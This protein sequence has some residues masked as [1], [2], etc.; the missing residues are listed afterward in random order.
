MKSTGCVQPLIKRLEPEWGTY[1]RGDLFKRDTHAMLPTCSLRK[2]RGI[3]KLLLTIFYIVLLSCPVMAYPRDKREKPKTTVIFSKDKVTYRTSGCKPLSAQ[4]LRTLM[5]AAFDDSKMAIDEDDYNEKRASRKSV[6][7]GGDFM[8]N[9]LNDENDIEDIAGDDD[10]DSTIS[11]QNRK[12]MRRKRNADV[13]YENENTNL[14]SNAEFLYQNMAF[15]SISKRKSRQKRSYNS[16]TFHPAWECETSQKWRKTKD[17][18]FPTRILDGSCV[19][20]KCFFGIYHCNP[21]KYAIKV[22]KRDPEN[23]CRP[24]PL[25]AQ[26]STY[27]ETWTFESDHVT[28]ACE[29]GLKVGR[30]KSAKMKKNWDIYKGKGNR[31]RND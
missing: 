21:V 12:F 2:I 9:Y 1:L 28:V 25:I 22:L 31:D 10:D 23:A 8:E 30:R 6:I 18:Y 27:E 7:Q 29:C 24:V 14:P 15:D 20:K 19:Q 17:G 13:Y 4:D 3:N 5:G 11:V 16:N 26:N